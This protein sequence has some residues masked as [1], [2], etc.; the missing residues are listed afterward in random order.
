MQLPS[1]PEENL[2]KQNKRTNT[3]AIIQLTES[4]VYNRF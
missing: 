1:L 3:L 4:Q 2:M